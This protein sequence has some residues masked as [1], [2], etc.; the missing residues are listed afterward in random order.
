MDDLLST[1]F[2]LKC[3]FGSYRSLCPVLISALGPCLAWVSVA[4]CILP[5]PLWVHMCI[6]PAVFGRRCFLGV[7]CH[8]WLFQSFRLI[9]ESLSEPWGEGVGED[10]LFRTD[11]LMKVINQEATSYERNLQ[12]NLVMNILCT[13][14]KSRSVPKLH[15]TS[16]P[17]L[18]T[19]HSRVLVKALLPVICFEGGRRL[20]M[21]ARRIWM[22]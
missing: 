21:T 6:S 16:P 10:I 8:L 20:W 15:V 11:F 19:H 7:I 2:N 9:S 14:T 4:L 22:I 17:H 5:W 13:H 3:N 12:D 1:V 18:H